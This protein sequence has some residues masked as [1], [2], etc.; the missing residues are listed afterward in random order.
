MRLTF[1]MLE[2]EAAKRG[3][4]IERESFGYAVWENAPGGVIQADCRTLQEAWS[5]I[6]YW[7]S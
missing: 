5:E 4:C 1:A 7:H 6:F 2:R 3:L